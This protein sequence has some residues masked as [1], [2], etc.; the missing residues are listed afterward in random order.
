MERKE[1]KTGK[2][3]RLKTATEEKTEKDAGMEFAYEMKNVY[4]EYSTVNI[5]R[6]IENTAGS[7]LLLIRN[8]IPYS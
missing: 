6:W 4:F 7:W 8:V 5:E 2:C 1:D 3:K